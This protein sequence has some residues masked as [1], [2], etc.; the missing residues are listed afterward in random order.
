MTQSRRRA[1]LSCENIA[2]RFSTLQPSGQM[3]ERDM[4]SRNVSINA[5]AVA[6]EIK[7]GTAQF[8]RD[9]RFLDT[10]FISTSIGQNKSAHTLFACFCLADYQINYR[11]T[12]IFCTC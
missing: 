6:A 10:D 4:Q 5:T 3:A 11:A 1:A 8:V 7:F 2:A 9:H 12:G